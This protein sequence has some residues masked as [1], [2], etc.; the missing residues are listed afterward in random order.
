MKAFKVMTF[1]FVFLIS[2]LGSSIAQTIYNSDGSSS[3]KIGGTIFHSDGTSSQRIGNTIFHSDGT[4]SQII[5]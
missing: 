5:K 2:V 4:T 3:Q 1:V